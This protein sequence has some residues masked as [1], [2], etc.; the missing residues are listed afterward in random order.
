M[1]ELL[2]N[3]KLELARLGLGEGIM[4]ISIIYETKD[5][6]SHVWSAGGFGHIYKSGHFFSGFCQ[7]MS[8]GNTPHPEIKNA[9][10]KK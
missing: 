6:N 3:A 1:N 5:G 4:A 10:L 2:K 9:E 8:A 7:R